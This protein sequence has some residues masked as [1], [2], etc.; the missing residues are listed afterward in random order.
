MDPYS[1]H[2]KDN[3]YYPFASLQD[4]ELKKFLLCS[5]LSMATINEFL[6]LKLVCC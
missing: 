2:R 4:W 1:H 3:L 6:R 5:S